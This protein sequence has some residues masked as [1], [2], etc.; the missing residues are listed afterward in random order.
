MDN[1]QKDELFHTCAW[2]F[3]LIPE[4]ADYYGFGAKASPDTDLDDKEDQFVSL[5]LTL[6]GK[7]TFAFVPSKSNTATV[8]SHDLVF[9]TCSEDCASSL[10]EAL[11]LERDVF[12]D[13]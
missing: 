12:Q 4:D 9:I 8:E 6:Q 10:K 13:D 11:D 1:P 5:K 2:C 7:S 3:N